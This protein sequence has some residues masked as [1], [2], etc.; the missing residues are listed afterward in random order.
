MN[1]TNF[2]LDHSGNKK[3]PTDPMEVGLLLHMIG[4]SG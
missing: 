3:S 4:L 2:N 1:H